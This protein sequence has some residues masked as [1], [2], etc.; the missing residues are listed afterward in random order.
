MSKY[1]YISSATTTILLQA[2]DYDTNSSVNRRG[3]NKVKVSKL[4]ITNYSTSSAT[5]KVWLKALIS[6]RT[7]NQSSSTTNKIIFDQE[8]YVS[9]TD[10]IEIGDNFVDSDSTI[11]GTVTHLNPDKDNTKEVQISASVAITNNETI[12]IRKEDYYIT[13]VVTIPAGVTLVLDDPFFININNH[14][15][16]LINTT[17]GTASLTIRID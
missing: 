6:T 3:S 14:S 4:S 7:V 8:N 1:K 11:H 17:E 2:S 15:L 10:K 9:D 5:A 16:A 13:G 12:N